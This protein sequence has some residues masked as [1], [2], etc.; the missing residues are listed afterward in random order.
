MHSSVL[1]KEQEEANTLQI[2]RRQL[3]HRGCG[4]WTLM[5]QKETTCQKDKDGLALLY[6]KMGDFDISQ[7]LLE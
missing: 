1:V 2:E 7:I 4:R 5:L 3:A 6:V